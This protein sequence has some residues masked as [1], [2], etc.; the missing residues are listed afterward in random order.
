MLNITGNSLSLE[1]KLINPNPLSKKGKMLLFLGTK[2]TLTQIKCNTHFFYSESC[3][4]RPCPH[5][6]HSRANTFFKQLSKLDGVGPVDKR[7]SADKLHKF[8]KKTKK[9]KKTKTCDM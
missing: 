1:S 7:P 6:R 3:V 9:T 4:F 8:V 2:G 5:T